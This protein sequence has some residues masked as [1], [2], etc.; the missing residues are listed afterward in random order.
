M[1]ADAGLASRR[2]CELLI[3]EGRV[4]VNGTIRR[5]L[6][7][8]VDPRVDRIEVDG[9]PIPQ[10]ERHIYIMLNKPGRTISTV[11][12]EPGAVRR[13]VLDLVDHPSRARLFP[14]GRLDFETTGL[15]LLTNDGELANRLTHPRYGVEKTYQVVVKGLLDDEGVAALEQGIYLAE[16]REGRTVGATRASHV[17][18]TVL[19]RDRERTILQLTLKEGRNRQVRRMLAAVGA[20][21]RSLERV[22]IGPVKLSKLARGA[23]RELTAGEL[24]ALRKACSGP[25]RPI[26]SDPADDG[27]KPKRLKLP[28]AVHPDKPDPKAASQGDARPSGRSPAPRSPGTRSRASGTAIGAKPARK[29]QPKVKPGPKPKADASRAR[30]AKPAGKSSPSKTTG[31]KPRNA[32]KATPRKGRGR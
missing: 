25:A 3:Q 20:P 21:V 12:D 13:T 11:R 8:L 4:R 15:V 28:R 6:P 16:R 18:L 2:A 22:A 24:G 7:V 17:G 32:R 29:A 27:I 26:A 10:P 1:L 30:P 23:W 31:S 5:E 9:R 14:V 19:R